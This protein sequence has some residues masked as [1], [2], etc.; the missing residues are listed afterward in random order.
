MGILNV[1]PDSFSDGGEFAGISE[2]AARAAELADQGADIIDIGGE[3]SRPGAEPVSV[4]VELSR[5]IPVIGELAGSGVTVPVSVDTCKP[6]VARKAVEAGAVIIN[7]IAGFRNPEMIET[8]A[9]TGAGIVIMHMQGEPRN[10]QDEPV[11]DDV[12]DDIRAWLEQQAEAAVSG[13]V[14]E[15]SIML[16]PG[17]G[18]GKTVEH[19]LE[20]LRRVREFKSAG[21]PVLIGASRKS[22]IGKTLGLEVGSRLPADIAVTTLCAV[23][24]V[25]AVRVHAVEENAAACRMVSAVL[26]TEQEDQT[27]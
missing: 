13:G 3:S 19:N 20:I 5:I 14:N 18:F 12:V 22:F 17:I 1:T 15:E 6:E 7:D 9:G 4:Q 16:D 10:M 23:S 26:N 24:G 2:A 21:F 8:A 27:E 25:D 11:Y